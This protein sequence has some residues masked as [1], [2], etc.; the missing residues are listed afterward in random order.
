MLSYDE[1]APQAIQLGAV[2]YMK[3]FVLGGAPSQF[4]N[5]MSLYGVPA[6]GTNADDF[7]GK[8]FYWKHSSVLMRITCNGSANPTPLRFRCIVYKPRRVAM[9]AGFTNDPS[10]SLFQSTNGNVVGPSTSG[11]GG[12]D[13]MLLNVNKRCFDVKHDFQFTMQPPGVPPDPDTWPRPLPQGT[14]TCDKVLKFYLPLN[15]KLFKDDN[16]P[17]YVGIG[18][19]WCISLF[20]DT[21]TRD[22]TAT[23]WEVS[24]RGAT[25]FMDN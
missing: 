21:V 2:A 11:V 6:P 15:R 24:T 23:D 5:F 13:L 10:T 16:R 19:H 18:H 9:Q 3:Q 8:S 20:A 17:D 22:G 12:T 7:S 4:T 1:L 14:Y 25:T